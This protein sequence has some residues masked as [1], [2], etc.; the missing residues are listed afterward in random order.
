MIK[1]RKAGGNLCDVL[2]LDIRGIGIWKLIRRIIL[3]A[4]FHVAE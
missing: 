1:S 2:Y 3:F 4:P